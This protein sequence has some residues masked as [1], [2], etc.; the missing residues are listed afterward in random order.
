MLAALFVISGCTTV[1][2]WKWL[3]TRFH[4]L[5][6]VR[7]QTFVLVPFRK[8]FSNSLEFRAY[9]QMAAEKLSAFGLLE[10]PI[11]EL[12]RT[13]YIFALDY[14]VGEPA[15]TNYYLPLFSGRGGIS[16]PAAPGAAAHPAA[17]PVAS[18]TTMNGGVGYRMGVVPTYRQFVHLY[19]YEGR[20]RNGHHAKRFEGKAEGTG[21]HNDFT[22]IV[23]SGLKALLTEFPGESG[24]SKREV[25]MGMDQKP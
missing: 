4:N 24:K 5:N 1:G 6:V 8:E 15:T 21:E 20:P 19:V 22:K 18:S 9:A 25:F 3:V 12:G 10:R 17:D 2:V 23:P 11:E 13:D 7:D 14:G 16:Q